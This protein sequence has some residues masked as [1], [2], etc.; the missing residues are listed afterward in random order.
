MKIDR[1]KIENLLKKHSEATRTKKR[2]P[3]TQ[4]LLQALGL[5]GTCSMASVLDSDLEE[6]R[7]AARKMIEKN[8]DGL[9]SNDPEE[10]R[11]TQENIGDFYY[12]VESG[13][14]NPA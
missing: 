3:L 8:L 14:P 2:L 10:V 1:T 6:E 11:K 9:L 5:E 7:A 13:A 12:C 4:E